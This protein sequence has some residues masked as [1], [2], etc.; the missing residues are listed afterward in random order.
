MLNSTRLV[1]SV[2]SIKSA[3]LQTIR[4]ASFTAMA[5]SDKHVNGSSSALSKLVPFSGFFK[6]TI[7]ERIEL[8][9]SSIP[10]TLTSSEELK[11]SLLSG[12][13]SPA[14]ADRMVEN[15]VG[16]L[17]L[18]LGVCPTVVMNGKH[19]IVPMTVEEPSVIAAVSGTSKLVAEQGGFAV[20]TSERNAMTGQIQLLDLDDM[21]AAKA[22]IEA[23]AEQIIEKI[24]R[25]Y[26][27]SMVR[28]GGGA[29]SLKAIA[30]PSA[31]VNRQKGSG[32][33]VYVTVDVCDSM[34]ANII[35]TICEQVAPYIVSLINQSKTRVALR[36][37]TN[38]CVDRTA[39][40]TFRLPVKSL[41]YKG[42]NGIDVARRIEEAYWFAC[43]DE[44]RAV[45]NNKGVM[46]GIDAVAIAC[47]QD[48][49]AI[50]S[51]AHAWA[52][53]KCREESTKTHEARYLPLCDYYVQGEGE[54]AVLVGTITIPLSVGT[55]GGSIQSHPLYK[56]AME[57]L[58]YPDAK[59][60]AGIMV[61]VGLAQN[62]AAIRALAIEGIQKGHMAL[63][64]KNIAVAAEAKPEHIN[65]CATFIASVSRVNKATAEEYVHARNAFDLINPSTKTA[66]SVLFIELPSSITAADSP[67]PAQP[68]RIV[69]LFESD[70]NGSRVVDLSKDNDAMIAEL[71]G[72]ADRS[73]LTEGITSGMTREVLQRTLLANVL[74]Q[75]LSTSSPAEGS[76][77]RACRQTL[78][79]AQSG[80]TTQTASL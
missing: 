2:R 80:Q 71:F 15:C 76:L 27:A 46:N 66:P 28:R 18:P 63:H 52:A 45:T 40:S 6:R 37:L 64:A 65:D 69:L 62:F 21:D 50:E 14:Q 30:R 68:I 19:Y 79:A 57:L 29:L 4:S 9:Q 70:A 5:S 31:M 25:E 74:K 38:L 60:L 20:T 1:A 10:Y 44:F 8:V 41:A 54:D 24:N 49:R 77:V 32:L 26:C 58:G 16:L 3:N 13:L 48:W 42:V 23:N 78:E 47:G 11:N 67:V 72:G 22:V 7:E 34:G 51:S 35:N 17:A 43:D 61:S 39:T 12:G 33:I 56:F 36:I 55:K 53:I 59:T 73:W 75:L